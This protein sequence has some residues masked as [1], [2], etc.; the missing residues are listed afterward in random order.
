MDEDE[1]EDE[2]DDEDE[3]EDEYED[4]DYLAEKSDDPKT[5]IFKGDHILNTNFIDEMQVIL[6]DKIY[7]FKWTSNR[8]LKRKN[9][10]YEK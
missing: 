5:I 1:D 9:I 6:D 3:D 10:F 4:D 2:D 8:L 7:Y